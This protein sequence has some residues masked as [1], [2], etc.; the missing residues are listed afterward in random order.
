MLIAFSKSRTLFE[1]WSGS[2]FGWAEGATGGLDNCECEDKGCSGEDTD[3]VWW[4]S[5]LSSLLLLFARG[6]VV[7]GLLLL[8]LVLDVSSCKAEAEV[9]VAVAV[10]LG[11]LSPVLVA[12][13]AVYNTST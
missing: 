11:D 4:S 5:L 3:D 12:S 9:V 2:E 6:V 10:A 13:T 8:L 1:F 7:V